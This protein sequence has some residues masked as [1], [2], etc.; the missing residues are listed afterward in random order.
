MQLPGNPHYDPLS[1]QLPGG[2]EEDDLGALLL[3]REETIKSRVNTPEWGW[4]CA[5]KKGKEGTAKFL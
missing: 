5:N 1:I 2:W 4:R 3:L